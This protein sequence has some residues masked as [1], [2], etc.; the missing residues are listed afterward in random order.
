MRV[1]ISGPPGSGKTTVAELVA[2]K[3]RLKLIL[4]GKIFRNQAKES[5]MDVHEY[6]RLAE[7]DPSI[8]KKLDDEIVRIAEKSD[9][10]IIEGRLAGQ[11][12][13]RKGVEAFK[14]FVTANAR[15]RAERIAKREHTKIDSEL[16]KLN[17]REASE[18]K[19]YQEYYGIDIGDLSV[20]DLIIDNSDLSAEES[21]DIVILEIRKLHK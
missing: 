2:K 4:T 13:G 19:R 18:R 14:V 20:Y 3:I 6:N 21:A 8:D 16:A 7:K 9:D 1:A 12:L 10:V 11:L 5:G 15:T 17:N